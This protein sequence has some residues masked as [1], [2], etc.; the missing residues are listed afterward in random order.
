M[1]QGRS[2]R[3]RQFRDAQH[4]QISELTV[5]GDKVAH[6]Y[7]V[8]CQRR[9]PGARPWGKNHNP[10]NFQLIVIFSVSCDQRYMFFVLKGRVTFLKLS[11]ASVP[12][13][14]HS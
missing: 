7:G 2:E 13:T 5:V 12:G 8:S 11:V 1:R 9:Q 6:A 3:K 14:D 4:M 10:Y